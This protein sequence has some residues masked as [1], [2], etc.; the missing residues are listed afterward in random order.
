[1]RITVHSKRHTTRGCS[2]PVRSFRN[3][4]SIHG[5]TRYPPN[6]HVPA[7]RVGTLPQR[8]ASPPPAGAATLLLTLLV[9]RDL[10][11]PRCR[12]VAS[13]RP[14]CW[15]NSDSFRPPP[16][17]SFCRSLFCTAASFFSA[18]VRTGRPIGCWG[19]CKGME[20]LN[21]GVTPVSLRGQRRATRLSAPPPRQRRGR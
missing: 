5:Q 14:C 4:P 2:F 17:C 11:R 3:H 20:T 10:L 18:V 21:L 1:M 12:L 8:A 7:W 16:A 9:L 6:D 13:H 15:S 19:P